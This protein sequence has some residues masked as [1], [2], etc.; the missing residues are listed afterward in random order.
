MKTITLP[1]ELN[2]ENSESV[3]VFH[4]F[5]STEICKQQINLTQNTFSFL[6]E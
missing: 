1:D 3:R 4:Y 6:T 2:V 5:N